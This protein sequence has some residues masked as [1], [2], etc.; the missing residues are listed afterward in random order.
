MVSIR[1]GNK[2][3]QGRGGKQSYTCS[4]GKPKR[5]KYAGEGLRIDTGVAPPKRAI[6]TYVCVSLNNLVVPQNQL[7]A[8]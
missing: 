4:P 1:K 7:E 5:Q 2:R 8:L 6:R 3:C